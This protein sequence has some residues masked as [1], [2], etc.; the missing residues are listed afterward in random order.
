M[1]CDVVTYISCKLD[2]PLNELGP[3][4]L[5]LLLDNKLIRQ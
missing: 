2:K 3:R 4:T 5:M 1:V